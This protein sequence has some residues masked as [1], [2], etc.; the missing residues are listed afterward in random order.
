MKLLRPMLPFISTFLFTGVDAATYGYIDDA[1]LSGFVDGWTEN[2]L[3]LIM[4]QCDIEGRSDLLEEH[5]NID[6][7]VSEI[8][9]DCKNFV[10]NPASV[11]LPA[12]FLWW[13]A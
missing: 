1:L 6:S 5:S 2:G 3:D 13:H 7:I 8:L 10:D 12:D 11:G 9:K 4:V